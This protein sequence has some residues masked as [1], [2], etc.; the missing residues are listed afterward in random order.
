MVLFNSDSVSE[1]D[2]IG[3]LTTHFLGQIFNFIISFTGGLAFK[4]ITTE[5]SSKVDIFLLK[6]R[7]RLGKW[8]IASFFK[9]N[10]N[11]ISSRLSVPNHGTIVLESS[12][13]EF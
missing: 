9:K 2:G 4:T 6:N 3:K 12:M 8:K 5:F 7:I 11:Q 10:Q 1:I 13:D